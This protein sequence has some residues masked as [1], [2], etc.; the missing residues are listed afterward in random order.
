[1]GGLGISGS[2]NALTA[3]QRAF[4]DA[5]GYVKVKGV[6]TGKALAE[7]TSAVEAI[8]RLESST[9]GKWLHYYESVR[10]GERG[11]GRGAIDREMK[12]TRTEHF[13]GYNALMSNLLLRGSI[14]G[15]VGS[16]LGE[17][18][19]L[20]KEKINYKHGNGGRGFRAHQD[21]PAYP[22][23][24]S[25]ATCL[26]C[27][28][29]AT[30]AN[31][32]LEF[33]AGRHREGLIGLTDDGI[34]SP[35]VAN[36]MDFLPV[37]TQPGDVL[38][39]SSYVPHRSRTNN[40]STSRRLLYLTYNAAREG[41]LRDEY[42]RDK[43]QRIKTGQL[44]LIKHFDGVVSSTGFQPQGTA[45]A[46]IDVV[47]QIYDLFETY[48]KTMYDP[49]VTQEE[50]A[51]QT[52]ALAEESGW[53]DHLVTAALLH[54]VG[55]LLLDEHAGND[56]F[57]ESD[58]CHEE[59]G[60]E[61]L[62][63]RCKFPPSVTEPIRLHVPAK[64][65]LARDPSYWEGLSDASKRSLEVQGGTFS[66]AEAKEFQDLPFSAEAAKLRE[67]DDLGKAKGVTTPPLS[68]FVEGAMKRSLFV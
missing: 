54:D 40:T 48:G 16:A 66:D 15:I 42:Y 30:E 57:L 52:A 3:S 38:V 27:V 11:A 25:H 65:F 41:Y 51:L 33:A 13:M 6:F 36:E 53:G 58:M 10:S 37:E 9:C 22:Q 47:D 18:A 60:A 43:M 67:L 35:D 39:F 34:I 12:L 29:A 31:G 19:F 24:R 21:A 56:S 62:S 26:V 5:N 64:R 68:H 4:Y 59:V 2:Q 28:D 45:S 50:H 46:A 44:S 17:P 1:M 55:H 8:E 14:P 20:Y 49:V 7:I 32:C 23:L 63:T 61:Y